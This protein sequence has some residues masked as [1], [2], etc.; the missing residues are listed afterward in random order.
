MSSVYTRPQVNPN[1]GSMMSAPQVNMT[2]DWQLKGDRLVAVLAN[3][4][5]MHSKKSNIR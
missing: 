1:V 2:L 5:R 3:T 4:T